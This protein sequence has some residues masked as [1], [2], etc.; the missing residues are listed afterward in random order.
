MVRAALEEAGV[1]TDL[2]VAEWKAD[3]AR[4]DAE[5]SLAAYVG[6]H[7]TLA[8]VTSDTRAARLAADAHRRMLAASESVSESVSDLTPT[9]RLDNGRQQ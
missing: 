6:G 2:Q 3:D 7:G 5:L 4:R 9:E 8:R 1:T